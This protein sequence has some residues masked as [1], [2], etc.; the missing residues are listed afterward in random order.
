[1]VVYAIP[2]MGDL[3]RRFPSRVSPAY[4]G[5]VFKPIKACEEISRETRE[6]EFEYVVLDRIVSHGEVL[7][8][9]DSRGFRPVLPEEL[10]SFAEKYP[11]EQWKYPIVALGSEASVNG[12]YRVACLWRDGNRRCLDLPW[13]GGRWRIGCRFLVVR[14]AA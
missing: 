3:N 1:M 7:A 5:A 11:D 12:G 6:I 13:I 2:L 8:E 4:D 14:K 10:I 9:I